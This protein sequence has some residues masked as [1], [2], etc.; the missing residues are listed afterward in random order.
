VVV[1]YLAGSGVAA[2]VTAI[3]LAAGALLAV[4]AGIGTLNGR[5]ALRSG[6]RQLLVG[7]IAAAVTFGVGHLIGGAVS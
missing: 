3:A 2:L 7:G 1:P 6:L 4:G 5:S